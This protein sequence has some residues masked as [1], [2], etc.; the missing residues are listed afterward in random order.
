MFKLLENIPYNCCWGTKFVKHT[1][2]L[3]SI[4]YNAMTLCNFVDG[5]SFS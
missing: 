1:A 4:I 3:S 5:V 2:E